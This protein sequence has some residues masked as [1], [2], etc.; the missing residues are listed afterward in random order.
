MTAPARTLLAATALLAAAYLGLVL[1]A[2]VLADPQIPLDARILAPAIV[3]MTLVFVVVGDAWWRGASIAGGAIAVIA[4]LAWNVG[5]FLDTRDAVRY[6]LNTGSDYADQCWR[7]SPVT[8]WVREHGAGHPLVSNA[9]VALYFHAGRLARE[10]PDAMRPADARAFRDTLVARDA[11]LVLF[12]QSCAASIDQPDSL[13]HALG[14]VREVQLARGSIWRAAPDTMRE[15]P[16]PSRAP[17]ARV[18]P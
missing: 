16:A 15:P 13:V 8:A 18:T 11:W 10:L 5:A 14:L 17:A 4:L 12:D 6:V 2:R 7:G 1:T 9:P 3:L